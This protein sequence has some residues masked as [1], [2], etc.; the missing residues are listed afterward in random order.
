MCFLLISI[1]L[2]GSLVIPRPKLPKI[3]SN[4]P[5]SV[6]PNGSAQRKELKNAS[7]I[8]PEILS[9]S[10]HEEKNRK[11]LLLPKMILFSVK[12]KRHSFTKILPIRQKLQKI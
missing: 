9:P 10:M 4:F 5:S 1:T 12:W 8:L 3:A 7:K 11:V 2:H 6:Q